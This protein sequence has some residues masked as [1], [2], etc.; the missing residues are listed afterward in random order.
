MGQL[1]VFGPG[2]AL[3]FAAGPARELDI[4]LLGGQPI[5]EPVA[6]YEPFVMNNRAELVQAF[7][8]YQAGRLGTIPARPAGDVVPEE[9]RPGARRAVA[10]AQV[11]TTSLPLTLL[12]CMSACAWTIWSKR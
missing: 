4:L 10:Q 6:A 11:S 9:P 2:E 3:T 5:R 1:A 7:E 12:A 8:D